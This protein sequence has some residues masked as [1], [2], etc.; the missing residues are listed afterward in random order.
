MDFIYAIPAWI[1]SA[2]ICGVLAIA[3][4]VVYILGKAQGYTSKD[5]RDAREA[6]R[7]RRRR[8]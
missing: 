4:L 7:R 5:Y 6:R 1:P 8:R 2:I 3:A